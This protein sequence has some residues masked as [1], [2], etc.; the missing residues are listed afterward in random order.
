L[1][2]NCALKRSIYDSEASR[3]LGVAMRLLRG[4]A[5]AEKAAHDTFVMVWQKA[6]SF[7]ASRGDG[8]SWL[9]TILRNRA[10]NILR[11]E[12]RTDLVEDFEPMG[13]VSEEEDAESVMLCLSDTGQPEALPAASGALAPPGHH[14]C[15]YP[16][17]QPRRARRTTGDSARHGQVLDT[18]V[19][20]LA[21]GVHGMTR[22]EHDRLAAEYV[23]GLLDGEERGLAERMFTSD[24][25]FQASVQQWQKRFSEWDDTVTDTPPT[26]RFGNSSRLISS[27]FPRSAPGLRQQ[28]RKSRLEACC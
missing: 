19:P 16:W 1:D 13:L 4:R 5:L 6:G 9:Y 8:R 23:L 17:S 22:D 2:L 11:G 20:D 7:D 10:L 12:S 15:L 18:P 3:M 28:R 27:R 21:A 14:P 25:A 26:K 24:A